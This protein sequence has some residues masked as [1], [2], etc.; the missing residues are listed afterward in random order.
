ML[1][2]GPGPL[3]TDRY[4]LHAV[5][6]FLHTHFHCHVTVRA[7]HANIQ[8][9]GA[10]SPVVHSLAPDHS[11]VKYSHLFVYR[12]KALLA[13][14]AFTSE[15][16]VPGFHTTGSSSPGWVDPG[17]CEAGP[18]RG[19][20]RQHVNKH[21]KKSHVFKTTSPKLRPL[22]SGSAINT[23]RIYGLAVKF[24]FGL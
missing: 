3:C 5:C 15:D 24:C 19:P 17:L 7:K 21:S 8:S 13:T 16:M 23:G 2:P 10:H 12:H 1:P 18:G 4:A 14:P 6:I 11:F 20:R 22:F 9:R